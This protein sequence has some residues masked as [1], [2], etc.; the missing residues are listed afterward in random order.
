VLV[1]P[2]LHV[3][4]GR[5]VGVGGAGLQQP[6]ESL[7]VPLGTLE[8]AHRALVPVELEPAQGVEDLRDVLGSRALAVGVL[9]PQDQLPTGLVAGHQPVV[10]CR[11]RATDVERSRRRR[12]EADPDWS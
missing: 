7:P 12:G 4:A 9:D 8:L 10:Q 11:P 6:L 1:L 5:G 2:D 3:V